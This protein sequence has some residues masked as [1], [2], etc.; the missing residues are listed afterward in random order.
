[1]RADRC[2]ASLLRGGLCGEAAAREVARA[3]NCHARFGS[4]SEEEKEYDEE[5]D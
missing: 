3:L 5:E 1:M 4:E 2:S